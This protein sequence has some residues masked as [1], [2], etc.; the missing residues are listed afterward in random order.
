V[1]TRSSWRAPIWW[2]PASWV[3]TILESTASPQN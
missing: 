3:G 2:I 1:M